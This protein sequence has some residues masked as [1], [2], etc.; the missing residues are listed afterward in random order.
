MDEGSGKEL[1]M[2]RRYPFCNTVNMTDANWKTE[3]PCQASLSV[4]DT[5]SVK[6]SPVYPNPV[7]RG[8]TFISELTIAQQV[9]FH[10]MMFQENY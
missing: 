1:W 9:K 4:K 8:M 10:C 7:K 6:E 3:V 2:L 5:E